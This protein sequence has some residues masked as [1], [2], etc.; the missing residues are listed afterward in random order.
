MAELSPDEEAGLSED[1]RDELDSIRA[2]LEGAGT[3]Q[4]VSQLERGLR[5]GSINGLR[6]AVDTLS[7]LPSSELRSR[8]GLTDQIAKARRVLQAHTLMWRARK[9]GDHLQ[10]LERA[11]TLIELV[12]KY[13]GAFKLR[14]EAAAA[15]EKDAEAAANQGDF[16][17][18][19]GLLNA[20]QRY[21]P[22][23]RGLADRLAHVKATEEHNRQQQTALQ[24]ASAALAAS[25]PEEGLEAL[26]GVRP[27]SGFAVRFADMTNRL[28][29]KLDEMDAQAPKVSL[30]EDIRLRYKKNEPLEIPL[31]VT[32]DY[33]V[34]QVKVMMRTE[35]K[36]A[37]RELSLKPKTSSHYIFNLTP[38]LHQNET[39]EFY[40]VATDRSGHTGFLGSPS[41]PLEVTRKKWYQR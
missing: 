26:R 25:R 7:K 12:P 5:T 40:V 17:R 37:Y 11:G 19:I 39:V 35:G 34:E 38:A 13:S 4:A 9:A 41:K 30:T 23:R 31:T 21:W 2:E 20:E 3:E 15:L 16:T 32:D 6:R 8:R 1:E 29:Q 14:E 36:P 22:K 27:D 24:R 28:Q 10:V 18:A 33:R